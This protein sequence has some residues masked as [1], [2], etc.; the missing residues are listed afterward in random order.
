MKLFRSKELIVEMLEKDET[1]I[2]IKGDLLKKL[3]EIELSML[4]DI[5]ALC[6]N[7]D[8]EIFLGGGSVL[9]AVRHGGFIPWDDDI[10][11]NIKRKYVNKLIDSI[12]EELSNKYTVYFKDNQVC[13]FIRIEKNNSIFDE[14]I[15]LSRKR[16]VKLDVFIIEDLPN[17]KIISFI[18]GLM[19]TYK[20]FAAS[21]QII[22][23]NNFDKFKSIMTSSTK[24][25]V[26][27]YFRRFI[28]FI[29]SYKDYHQRLIDNDKYFSKYLG[30]NSKKVSIMNGR[31]HYFGEMYDRDMY[32]NVM[33][34]EF[35]GVKCKIQK[36]YDAYLK[37]LYGDNYMEL[38][39]ENKREHHYVFDVKL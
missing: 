32:E 19:C 2:E 29:F 13:P 12:K 6:N 17:N 15:N 16:G 5:V 27:Y 22:Y 18:Y 31:R 28:G 11:L 30:S 14:P 4:K 3:Q 33:E 10:D 23:E 8:I 35:E 26:N 38:P 20:L 25:K 1:A 7:N 9:G 39:P 34:I 37:N 21:S 24:A 36:N